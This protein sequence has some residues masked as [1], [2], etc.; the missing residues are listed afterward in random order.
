MTFLSPNQQCQSTEGKSYYYDYVN[1]SQTCWM[2]EHEFVTGLGIKYA[3]TGGVGEPSST[4][5]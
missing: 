2:F 4:P 1:K 3:G 5:R